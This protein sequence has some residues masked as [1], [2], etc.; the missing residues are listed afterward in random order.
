MLNDT[1][2]KLLRILYNRN[3]HQNARI[4]I[5]EL[6][7][8]AG[9]EA[10]QIRKALERLQEERFIEWEETLNVVKV[11]PGWQLHAK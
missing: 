1:E 10:G 5:P 6:A 3:G 7:R 11:V 8:L 9:R 2:R 4:L